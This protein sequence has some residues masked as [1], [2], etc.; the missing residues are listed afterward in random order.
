EIVL[1]APHGEGGWQPPPPRRRRWWLIPLALVVVMA[2]A[3]AFIR[4]P[5][6]TIAPGSSR[7]V[8]DLVLVRGAPSYPPRGKVLYS[9]VSVRERISPYDYLIATLSS[10]IDVT[11][12]KNVRGN[13]PPD[14]FEQ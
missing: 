14:Q 7:E 11:P 9:T 3:A 8:N 12:E 13:T 4:L 6:D 10:D 5:Y 1:S 2:I